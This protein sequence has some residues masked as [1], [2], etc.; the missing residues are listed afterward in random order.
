MHQHEGQRWIDHASRCEPAHVYTDTGH[1]SHIR[2][3]AFAALLCFVLPP[4]ATTLRAISTSLQGAMVGRASVRQRHV[5]TSFFKEIELE[6]F[7]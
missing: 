5:S 1:I 7:W 3:I 4:L 2:H 6:I